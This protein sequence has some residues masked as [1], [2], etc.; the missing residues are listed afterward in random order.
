M[1]HHPIAILLIS[2]ISLVL[3]ASAQ[4]SALIRINFQDA[5]VQ[6]VLQHLSDVAGLVIV[7]ADPIEGRITVMSR[8]DMTIDEAV[9]VLNTVLKEKGFASIRTG[10][11]L[12]IVKLDQARKMNIPV[13]I[14]AD[15][16]RIA[17]TDEVI[18]Q[19]IPV[20]N[21][22]AQQLATDLKTLISDEADVTS[23][24]SSNSIVITDSSANIRRMVTI[25]AALDT[26]I[27][28]V[29]QVRVF[30]LEYA[31][32][33][34]AARLINELF[35]QGGAANNANSRNE[36]VRSFFRGPRGRQDD[37]A[38][39]DDGATARRSD[40]QIKASADERTNTV[41]VTAP[42]ETLTVIEQVLR[43]LDSNRTASQGV[44]VYNVVHSEAENLATLLNEL[45]DEASN[46]TTNQRGNTNT[47]GQNNTPGSRGGGFLNTLAARLGANGANNIA[48]GAADLVGR[49]KVVAD[50]TTN[51]LMVMTVPSLFD[52]VLDILKQL[53]VAAPQ[54]LIK[55]LV[56]EVTHSNGTDI[57]LEYSATSH[58]GRVGVLQQ[59][60]IDSLLAT[61]TTGGF[62]INVVNANLDL[63][64]RA[65]KEIGKLEILSRPYILAS[66]N[67]EASITVG[68]EVPFVTNTQFTELGGTRNTIRYE[69]V[70][71]ILKVTPHI[72]PDGLVTMDVAPEISALSG[73][74][75]P[76]S[77]TTDAPVIAKRSAQTRVALRS[78]QTIIIGGLMEDRKTVT[79]RQVP[80][81][82]D[83]P[84]IG[85]LFGRNIEDT[86]KTELLIFLTPQVAEVPEQLKPMT[87]RETESTQILH[88]AVE[89]GTFDRHI[90]DMEAR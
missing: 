36:A 11:T 46:T 67:Q 51:S 28:Q 35:S 87:D 34:D 75:V 5:P 10:R 54:V 9:A 57:G 61:T 55:V 8:Q 78:G 13:H 32:A 86:S 31:S 62:A 2:F 80:I 25:I 1:K 63:T 84:L 70:G 56:A 74:T 4:E 29:A 58:D 21:A 16:A 50:A 73:E 79:R 49:V 27:D 81:L 6:T 19:V 88:D 26:A 14:G 15:P 59:F 69:D 45:F 18:T 65:L 41:V 22:E 30:T 40:A 82:G 83:L 44:F 39:N 24:V 60:G 38:N 85:P 23:N 64:I 7:Q 42:P 48:S 72:G 77:D 37:S 90:H 76:I 53:D 3:P 52:Q 66:D 47:N 12:K 17:E 33:T 71:I 43:D 89:E 20:R 68:Q